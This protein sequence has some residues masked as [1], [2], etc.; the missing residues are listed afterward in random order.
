MNRLAEPKNINEVV[1][2]EV[3]ILVSHYGATDA[4]IA[5]LIRKHVSIGCLW[6]SEHGSV[7]LHTK[8]DAKSKNRQNPRSIRWPKKTRRIG[9]EL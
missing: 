9:G 4:Q 1:I 8:A 3:E 7:S 2:I 6:T 5:D